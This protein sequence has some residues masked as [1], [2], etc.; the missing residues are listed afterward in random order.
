M[1]YTTR[2]SGQ[3][4]HQPTRATAGAKRA[5]AQR[6]FGCAVLAF[7]CSSAAAQSYPVRPIRM[8]VPYA[9]GGGV[10]IVARTLAQ[11]LSKRLGQSVFVENK[12]G[13]GSNIG[14]DAVAK[15]APDGY[16]LLMA[17]PANAINAAL[18][19][20]MP[21]NPSRDLAPIALVGSVPGVLIAHPSV[22]ARNATELVAL[23]K[24]R[25]GALTY[26]T[27]GSGTSEHLSAE[28][29]KS[30]AGVD[31]LHVPYKG[32]S[33]VLTDLIGGQI[34][35]MFVNQ[36]S[37]VPL[38]KSGKVRALAVAS[39]KRSPALPEVATFIEQGFPDFRVSVWWGVMGPANTP[40][41][42]VARLNQEI[43]AAL[44]SAEMK[45]RLEALTAQPIGG[46]PEQ[47][48]AFFADELVRWA[49]VVQASGAK[50]D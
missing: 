46:T 34:S 43:V 41:E 28:M 9:A 37:A 48:A 35:V 33:A 29:F 23:A 21:Y 32:G 47:F 5:R 50:V 12:P 14:S 18:Y 7:F 44:A 16:T 31:L 1:R 39:E 17:S 26:G 45:E 27:G 2:R 11:E 8:I 3:A 20:K 40:K 4:A 25:P 22:A 30:A 49:R 38:V 42:I 13:A 36:I 24:A 19:A 6:L 15:A 10:D